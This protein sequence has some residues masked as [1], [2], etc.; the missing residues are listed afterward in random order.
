[1]LVCESEQQRCLYAF[2]AKTSRETGSPAL[3]K[4][5]GHRKRLP[6]F[7]R[8]FLNKNARRRPSRGASFQ[9]FGSATRFH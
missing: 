4:M 2:L 9:R 3:F 6:D 8:R 7:V 1:M 5:R